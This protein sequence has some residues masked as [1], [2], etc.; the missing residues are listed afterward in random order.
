MSATVAYDGAITFNAQGL[1]NCA[2]KIVVGAGDVTRTISV[3]G[4]SGEIRI[5]QERVAPTA[6]GPASPP[7]KNQSDSEPAQAICA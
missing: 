2:G 6:Q 3:D 4:A 5:S 7:N 1:P